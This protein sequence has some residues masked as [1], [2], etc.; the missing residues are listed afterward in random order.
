MK[1]KDMFKVNGFLG[2]VL[3]LLLG[4]ATVLAI[5]Q[6]DSNGNYL[7]LVLGI[8]CGLVMFLLLTGLTIVQPN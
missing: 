8:L 6:F 4:A 7:L 3:F 1:E 2:I 5:I